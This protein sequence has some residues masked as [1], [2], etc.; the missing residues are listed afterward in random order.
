MYVRVK[1]RELMGVN[2]C[3]TTYNYGGESFS[4][5]SVCIYVPGSIS[6]QVSLF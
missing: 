4:D 6:G 5:A 1:A 2:N 3:V